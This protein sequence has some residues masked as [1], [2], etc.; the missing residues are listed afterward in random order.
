MNEQIRATWVFFRRLSAA[1]KAVLLFELLA[2]AIWGPL[3]GCVILVCALFVLLVIWP[4]ADTMIASPFVAMIF[5]LVVIG[6]AIPFSTPTEVLAV[7]QN[8]LRFLL[9]MLASSVMLGSVAIPSD[10]VNLA[11][12]LR[13]PSGVTFVIGTVTRFVP[14][15]LRTM[16]EVACAQK[17]RGLR[18][19][20]KTSFQPETYTM[21]LVPYVI[22]IIRS[23][24]TVWV[25]SN[26]RPVPVM[27][28]R[29]HG[30]SKYAIV[31]E[32]L[33]LYGV[34]MLWVVI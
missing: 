30:R 27:P 10:F 20:L 33:V 28:T 14:L 15:C 7:A 21:L 1:F 19:G 12:L 29:L 17:A 9:F 5:C 11:H 26:L 6:T 23:A 8:T 31:T 2:F 34:A 3:E 16:G 13:L 24:V 22:S 18:L 32:F 4:R 25:A